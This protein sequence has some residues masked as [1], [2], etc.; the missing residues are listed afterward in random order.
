MIVDRNKNARGNPLRV[1]IMID[2]GLAA[3]LGERDHK[4]LVKTLGSL[5]KRDGNAAGA[6]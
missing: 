3:E 1:H 6:L 2:C 5:I 4:N